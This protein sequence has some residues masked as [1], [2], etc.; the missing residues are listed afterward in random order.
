MWL[1]GSQLVKIAENKPYL[2]L[3]SLTQQTICSG[4]TLKLP[5]KA[6]GT[7]DATNNFT[8]QLSNASG[9]FATPTTL[10]TFTNVGNDSI[11]CALPNTLAQGSNYR[12]R[13]LSSSPQLVSDT[14]NALIIN[15]MPPISVSVTAS[16]GTQI[17]VGTNAP[18]QATPTNGGNTPN[19]QWKVNGA[20]VGTNAPT[21]N[22]T[23]L[24]DG[25]AIWVEMR[26]SAACASVTPAQSAPVSMQVTTVN[27]PF[28]QTIDNTLASSSTIGN[29]WFLNGVA[30]IGATTPFYTLTSNA[31]NGSYTV[32][33]TQNGCSATSQAISFAYAPPSIRTQ[34]LTQ[35]QYCV[36]ATLKLPY[37]LNGNFNANATFNVELSNGT[38]SFVAPTLVSSFVTPP[39]DS[40]TCSLPI[41]LT[42]GNGY[43]LRITASNPVAISDTTTPLTITNL[44]IPTIQVSGHILASSS[45][46][47]NQWFFNGQAIVG[48]TNQFYTATQTGFYTVRVTQNGCQALSNLLNHIVSATH[49]LD[50]GLSVHVFPNPTD[51]QLWIQLNGVDKATIQIWN[52]IGQVL[53]RQDVT[54]TLTS[55]DLNALP[56]GVYY[57]HIIAANGK[58]VQKV[59]LQR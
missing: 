25:D 23:T 57:V 33:V 49:D 55:L 37:Y 8:V 1:S 51:G 36:G 9:S 31:Q 11:E 4:N 43:R 44:P 7:F 40:I 47:G 13:V 52:A 34:T 21:F 46:S 3:S 59:V 15:G 41:S 56:N 22:T 26:S 6:I 10:T 2:K 29:Q 58:L 19:Y 30:L 45:A 42:T 35:T 14:S 54:Q 24:Q 39:V 38:G 17:C 53:K 48:A 32:R 5:V 20:N 16:N 12:L 28:I 50:N 27:Q 18:F